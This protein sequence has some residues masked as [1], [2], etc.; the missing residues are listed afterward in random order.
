M[1]C[2]LFNPLKPLL[3]LT[4]EGDMSHGTKSDFNPTEHL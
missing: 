2:N 4:C 1:I 3:V